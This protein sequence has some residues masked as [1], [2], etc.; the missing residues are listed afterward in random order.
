MDGPDH[1]MSWQLNGY[2]EQYCRVKWSFDGGGIMLHEALN[3][4]GTLSV[5]KVE[6]KIDRPKVYRSSERAR[7]S[8][9]SCQKSARYFFFNTTMCHVIGPRL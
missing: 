9:D 3:F 7:P 5:V 1:F 2:S 6:K 8:T 4:D